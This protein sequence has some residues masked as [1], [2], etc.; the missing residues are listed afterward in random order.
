MNGSHKSVADIESHAGECY[1]ELES[2]WSGSGG[3]SNISRSYSSTLPASSRHQKFS[4]FFGNGFGEKGKDYK[5]GN[6]S[7]FNNDVSKR[8]SV[9]SDSDNSLSPS[10]VKS[11]D[12]LEIMSI[13]ASAIKYSAVKCGPLFKKEKLLFVE[14]S[15]RYW[16]ALLGTNLYIYTNEKDS[17]P[18]N[19][20]NVDEYNARAMSSSNG[21]KKDFGF[22]IVCPGKKTYQFY[23][24]SQSE[25]EAW[26]SSINHSLPLPQTSSVTSS[27]STPNILQCSEQE[28]KVLDFNE[29]QRPN[30][31]RY[32][33]ERPTEREL[34]SIPVFIHYDTPNPLC[35]S[36]V[37]NDQKS[38]RLST[39]SLD[40]FFPETIYHSID[41]SI[42]EQLARY[43]YPTSNDPVFKNKENYYQEDN[44]YYNILDQITQKKLSE[45]GTLKKDQSIRIP[46]FKNNNSIRV[47][48]KNGVGR[49]R[50]LIQKMEEI[51]NQNNSHIKK[52]NSYPSESKL[53]N[54]PVS[55][56]SV[57][58]E[59]YELVNSP[60]Y[61]NINA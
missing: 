32:D 42:A 19:C 46:S 60:T 52:L 51:N 48:N 30:S 33:N 49:I 27:T 43:D 6:D 9:L 47:Y 36:V 40:G 7:D 37:S 58:D 28:L 41:E 4:L 22:E 53:L 26:I 17:K 56:I 8:S 45:N 39:D 57:S 54:G 61:V 12:S 10:S 15:K 5:N 20:V 31:C 44:L 23:S 55:K 18:I 13:S 59:I 14:H 50:Q 38:P 34:P 25:M 3:S 24:T 1:E 21:N 2:S 16:A 11:E 35:R 29:K